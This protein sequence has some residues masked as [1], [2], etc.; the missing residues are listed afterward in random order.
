MSVE[1][2]NTI[3]DK[4]KK[5]YFIH[6]TLLEPVY[7]NYNSKNGQPLLLSAKEYNELNEKDRE[8]VFMLSNDFWTEK[9]ENIESFSL[10]NGSVK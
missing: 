5:I 6:R 8:N 1:I 2:E 7:I 10:F 4:S 9:E 3:S